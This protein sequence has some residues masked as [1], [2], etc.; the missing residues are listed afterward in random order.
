MDT[1]SYLLGCASALLVG[2]SKTGL[3]GVSIPAI[4]L[5]AEA[6][7][8]DAKLSLGAILPVLLVGDVFAVAWYRHHAQWN[9]LIRLFPYVIAGML[10]GAAVLWLIEGNQLRPLLGG[11]ILGLLALEAYRR[12]SV[13]RQPASV[14]QGHGDESSEVCV[15]R[16][17][18]IGGTDAQRAA[19]C[20]ACGWSKRSDAA[21]RLFSGAWWFMVAMGAIAG[22]STVIA[23]AAMP[24]MTIYFLRSGMLKKEFIGTAA[25]FFFVLNLTK[26]PICFCLHVVTPRTLQLGLAVAP[27]T[28]LG[29]LM[30]VYVLARIPQR[31]FDALA[32]SLA[33]I[34]AL[35]LVVV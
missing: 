22:F 24:V 23:N 1:T 17:V 27:V 33:G 19:D 26:L 16:S 13:T 2:F 10:P 7:S 28:L 35:R 9:R 30:G 5:M 8:D 34:A 18:A 4:L 20:C 25:W 29:A 12:W 14:Q 6:F 3:P 15:C 32:L 11:L 21:P 31:F